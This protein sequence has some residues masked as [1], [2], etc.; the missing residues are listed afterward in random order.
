MDAAW[1]SLL[2]PARS[3]SK[4][5]AASAKVMFGHLAPRLGENEVKCKVKDSDL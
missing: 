1:N 4:A 2:W 3:L 5:A